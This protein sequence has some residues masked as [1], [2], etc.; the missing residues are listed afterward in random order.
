MLMLECMFTLFC[1]SLCNGSVHVCD[2][3]VAAWVRG[4]G[5]TTSGDDEDAAEPVLA[6][7]VTFGYCTYRL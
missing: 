1:T 7:R 2:L 5:V 4:G 6:A 3:A